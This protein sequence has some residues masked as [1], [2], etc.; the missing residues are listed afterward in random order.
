M[1]QSENIL[2]NKV[3]KYL[4]KLLD[5]KTDMSI[6]G[7]K[8]RNT[9]K[10]IYAIIK[11]PENRIAILVWKKWKG[12]KVSH[13]TSLWLASKKIKFDFDNNDLSE[14]SC[15]AIV[16]DWTVG[17]PLTWYFMEKHLCKKYLINKFNS[18][19]DLHNYL[20]KEA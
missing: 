18:I 6:I 19:T 16:N 17:F 10:D 13:E 11:T 9:M 5:F 1:K 20:V 7:N 8:R 3:E 2:K 15:E 4:K 14:E 12:F